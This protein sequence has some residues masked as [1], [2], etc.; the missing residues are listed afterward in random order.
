MS[1]DIDLPSTFPGPSSDGWDDAARDA[2]DRL[3]KGQLIKFADWRWTIGKEKLAVEASRRFMALATTALWQRWEDGEVVERIQRQPN[4]RL[5][6][7]EELSHQDKSLWP[8]FAGEPQ[9]P[10]QNTRYVYLVDTKTQEDLTFSTASWGGRAAVADLGEQIERMRLVHPD[11]VP[12]V[13]LHARE[14]PTKFGPKSK[15]YFK[16]VGW[17][18]RDNAPIPAVERKVSPQEAKRLVDKMDDEIPF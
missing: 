14:M 13:E 16:V 4:R 2:A 10:W 11:A 5:P 17:M 15:P 9:D 3:L 1:N 8:L 7:R 12:I 18:T 6:E